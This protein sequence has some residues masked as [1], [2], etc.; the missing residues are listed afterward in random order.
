MKWTEACAPAGGLGSGLTLM[1][2]RP[3]R[4]R[5]RTTLVNL[6]YLEPRALPC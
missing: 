6:G 5:T 1:G 3:L 4:H 2:T